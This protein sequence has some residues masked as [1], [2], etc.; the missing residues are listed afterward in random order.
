[1]PVGIVT[2]ALNISLHNANLHGHVG[3]GDI[4]VGYTS[5]Q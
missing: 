1:M 4:I 3:S 5:A 2:E